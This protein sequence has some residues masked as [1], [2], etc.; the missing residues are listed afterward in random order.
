MPKDADKYV[1]ARWDKDT[2]ALWF[3][4]SWN[5]KEQAQE[6][7]KMIDGIVVINGGLKDE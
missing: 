1:V 5:N 4:G 3:Y 7:S 6:I 2:S